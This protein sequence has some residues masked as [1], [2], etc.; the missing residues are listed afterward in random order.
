[1]KLEHQNFVAFVK[2]TAIMCCVSNEPVGIFLLFQLA[3]RCLFAR[4]D[5]TKSTFR[6]RPAARR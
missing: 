5:A 4:H 3:C 2:T 1:L 6:H